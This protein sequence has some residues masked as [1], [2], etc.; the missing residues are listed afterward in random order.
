MRVEELGEFGLID[1]IKEWVG[2]S[3]ESTLLG[4]DDDAAVLQST[5][6]NLLLLTT[7]AFLEGVHFDLSY[8]N[9]E[10]LGWRALAA[11]LSDIA[12]MGGRP[13]SA[14]VSL[15]IPQDCAVKDIEEFYRGMK[16]LADRHGTS[17]VGGDTLRSPD[18]V[19][20]S[21][22]ITGAVAPERVMRRS[23]AHPGDGIFVTG[24]L[25]G[26]RAGLAILQTKQRHLQSRFSYSIKKHLA[27]EP[28]VNEAQFLVQNFPIHAMIDIS[29][30]LI[31]EVRHICRES[32]VGA[33][34]LSE[35]IPLNDETRQIAGELQHD[36]LGYALSGGEDFEL[37]FAAPVELEQELC[38]A[39]RD[40]F[41][42]D[43][44]RVGEVENKDA[45]F[46][47]YDSD[48]NVKEITSNGGYDHF[49]YEQSR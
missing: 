23:G 7:D 11:N 40:K 18:R 34:L 29:D 22:A 48:G 1:R 10:Q 3:G 28:R 5:G 9:F 37:L 4:I 39:F 44:V 45:G 41:G 13:L 17:I 2:Q 25:G 21:V 15:A 19:F 27:P 33:T 43:C 24:E 42:Y 35:R 6:D 30:G 47:L 14:V 20:V 46:H 36:P 49:G 16:A 8:I 26:A 12:A 31:S 38:K 32:S